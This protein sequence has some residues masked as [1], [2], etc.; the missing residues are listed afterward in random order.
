MFSSVISQLSIN[1][2]SLCEI[3]ECHNYDSENSKLVVCGLQ[4]R[5]NVVKYMLGSVI[6]KL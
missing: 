2:W 6:R 1:G 4:L 3:V 5:Y